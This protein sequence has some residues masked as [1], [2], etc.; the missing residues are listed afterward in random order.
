MPDGPVPEFDLYKEL[1]VH[2]RASSEVIGAAYRTI[3]KRIHPDTTGG[4]PGAQARMKRL[5]LA[6][7]WLM[8]PLLRAEY[9]AL[10]KSLKAK[11]K[12]ASTSRGPDPAGRQSSAS[13]SSPVR[14]QSSKQNT[15]HVD[16]D[17]AWSTHTTIRPVRGAGDSWSW[18]YRHWGR[19]ARV[20][21]ILLVAVFALRVFAPHFLDTLAVITA[22][23]VGTLIAI[24]LIAPLFLG[25][26]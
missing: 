24:V 25:R 9:D 2:P 8:D 14:S 12:S 19:W 13:A 16:A 4:T 26:R 7:E 1:E 17:R 5:N 15:H 6:R 11:R 20:V 3:A 22:Y 10:R 18:L 21:V 23:G